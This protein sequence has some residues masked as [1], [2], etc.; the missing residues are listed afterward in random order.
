MDDNLPI[1][2]EHSANHHYG[3]LDFELQKVM[4]T[5]VL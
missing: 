5:N 4:F 1:E 3:M 2:Y